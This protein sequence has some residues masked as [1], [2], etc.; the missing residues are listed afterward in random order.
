MNW[1]HWQKNLAFQLEK[2]M[3][4]V[5]RYNP[6]PISFWEVLDTSEPQVPEELQKKLMLFFVSVLDSTISLQAPI[7]PSRTRM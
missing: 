7:L 3:R 4:A 1:L 5:G 6:I 2:H